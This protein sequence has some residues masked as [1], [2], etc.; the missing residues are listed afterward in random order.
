MNIDALLQ[1]FINLIFKVLVSLAE[2][3]ATEGQNFGCTLRKSQLK[4]LKI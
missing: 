3:V 2:K 1:V 4:A